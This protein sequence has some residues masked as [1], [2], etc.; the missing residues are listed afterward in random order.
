VVTDERDPIEPPSAR[1]P[2]PAGAPRVRTLLVCDLADSTALVERLGDSAAAELIRRHDRVA[3]DLMHRHGGRE[4]DKT[5]GFLVLFERPVEAVA[6]A[7]AYQRALRALSEES[8]HS[9]RAR[10][11]VHVGEVVLWENPAA[12]VAAGAKPVDVEG[13]AKPVVARLMALALPGQIILSGVA[14]SLAQRAERELDGHGSVRWLTHGRYRFKGVAAPMLVH[15]VGE[16]GIAPLHAPPSGPKAE[17]DVPLWRKPGVLALEGIALLLAI[18]VPLVLSLRAPPAIAFGE[19][20]WIVMGDLRNLTG[21]TVLDDSLEIAF[22]ISL[23]QSRYVNVL[24]D[25]KLQDALARMQR[26][27]DAEIDR[28]VASEIALREGA[29][30]V[31]LPT[32]AEIGGRVRVSAEVIDPHTQTTVYAESA[33]GVGASSTLDSID[34]VTHQLRA[35]LGEALAA[36]ESGSAP[37]PRVTTSSLAALRHFALGQRAYLESRLGD[38][39]RNY[40]EAVALDDGF[41]L[42]RIGLAR[43]LLSA[44]DKAAARRYAMEAA[45]QSQRLTHRDALYVD[46]FVKGFGPPQAAVDAWRLLAE[47]YPDFHVASYNAAKWTWEYTGDFEGGIRSL[48]GAQVPI[49]PVRSEAYYLQGSL[50]LCLDRLPA[51]GE[52]FAQAK[53]LGEVGLNHWIAARH[54]ALREYDQAEAIIGGDVSY[55]LDD[56]DPAKRSAAVSLLLDRGKIESAV[57]RID[58]ARASLGR[59]PPA[60]HLMFESLR[61]AVGLYVDAPEMLA[62]NAQ[63]VAT[64]AAALQGDPQDVVSADAALEALVAAYVMHL[65]GLHDRADEIT[66]SVEGVGVE[67]PS[68]IALRRM[69]DAE[70]LLA[71]GDH[72]AALATLDAGA[73]WRLYPERVTRLRILDSAGDHAETLAQAQWLVDHR[74][75]ALG[76]YLGRYSLRSIA[77]VE[78]NLAQLRLAELQLALGRPKESELALQSFLQHWPE[79]ATSPLTSARV[80]ALRNAREA[81]SRAVATP[82][83]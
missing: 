17:R 11:G 16:P 70:R 65:K 22:R 58:E 6:F 83:G 28:A 80:A 69:L 57:T 81:A 15:E 54:M 8:R 9:L 7:L 20:D 39:R 10:V 46:A 43:V 12:D 64:R 32:V 34:S 1:A 19:R 40:A 60:V 66:R 2:G 78:S 68:M 51:S 77:I 82:S 73:G 3:R 25:L 21:E 41:A 37:L 61:S 53:A 14:F 72:R 50:E 13:L 45:S 55:G 38:A 56:G 48:A 63:A 27:P 35:K 29:R 59:S 52:S 31:I 44:G 62:R 79:A 18:S 5:D 26:E 36:I 75:Q 67:F 74:G 76:E 33:D 49:S 4:I 30:A 71:A 23:E 47:M 24:P 42:A